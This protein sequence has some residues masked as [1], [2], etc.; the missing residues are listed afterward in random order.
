MRCSA[1]GDMLGARWSRWVDTDPPQHM[2]SISSIQ[3]SVWGVP[4]SPVSPRLPRLPVSPVSLAAAPRHRHGDCPVGGSRV[5]VC[6]GGELEGRGMPHPGGT[7]LGLYCT[8]GNSPVRP[9]HE[10]VGCAHAAVTAPPRCPPP[11]DQPPAMAMVR[12]VTAA[13]WTLGRLG[14]SGI[15][16]GAASTVSSAHQGVLD[17]EGAGRLGVEDHEALLDLGFG[18]HG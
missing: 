8:A 18:S 14:N 13:I 10:R 5:V 15:S 6:A 12:V 4:I 2:Q 11:V 16:W 9:S 3:A 17:G 7:S 1:L